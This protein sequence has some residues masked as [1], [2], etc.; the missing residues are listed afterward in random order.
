MKKF[1]RDLFRMPSP[2]GERR[3]VKNYF[4]GK[5]VWTKGEEPPF[6]KTTTDDFSKSKTPYVDEPK[7]VG[8]NKVVVRTVNYEPIRD[9]RFIVNFEGIQP[10]FIKSYSY[11]GVATDRKD[12]VTHMSCISVY[13]PASPSLALENKLLSLEGKKISPITINVLDSIGDL[14]RQ[15][16]LSNVVVESVSLFNSFDYSSGDLQM[17]EVRFSHKKKKIIN[18]E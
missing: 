16:E 15:I 1:L 6:V 4:T 13:L 3:L 8:V 18:F 5:M 10:Y 11:L 7:E 12:S 2:T 9:G 17:A 14:L